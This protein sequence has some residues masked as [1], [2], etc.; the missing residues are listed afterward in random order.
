M[1]VCEEAFYFLSN[2][3]REDVM[4]NLF[5]SLKSNRFIKF[6]TVSIGEKN[7]NKYFTPDSIVTL[8]QE[9]GFIVQPEASR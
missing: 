5:H 4:L 9:S 2:K 8:L 3:E 6:A 1:I 7:G